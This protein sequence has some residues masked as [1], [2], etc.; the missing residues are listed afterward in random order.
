MLAVPEVL[1]YVQQILRGIFPQVVFHASRE[2]LA[3]HLGA[4]LQVPAQTTLL[5][6]RVVI[7]GR[8]RDQRNAHD[9]GNNE[10]DAE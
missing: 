7:R 3:Q 10:P 6:Q 2:A 8:E 5:T 4:T 9:E 1:N